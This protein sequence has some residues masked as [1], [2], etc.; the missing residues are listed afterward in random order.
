MTP[1][2][3]KHAAE[4]GLVFLER[5]NLGGNEVAAW[6]QANQLLGSILE[7]R[8]EVVATKLKEVKEDVS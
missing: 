2:Q 5:T 3:I 4:A 7:G 6:T 8:L 1:E